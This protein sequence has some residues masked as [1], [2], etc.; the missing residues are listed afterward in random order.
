MFVAPS[1][2]SCVDALI[3]TVMV[4]EVGLWGED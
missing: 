1:K 4:M 2:K 3:L